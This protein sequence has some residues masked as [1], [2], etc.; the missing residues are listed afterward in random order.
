MLAWARSSAS[1][2][3]V[4]VLLITQPCHIHLLGE[5]NLVLSPHS[6]QF[7]AVQGYWP[8]EQGS[9]LELIIRT[10]LCSQPG[11]QVKRPWALLA[12]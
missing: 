4:I 9:A 2:L 11:T 12:L 5:H 1:C 8:A 7:L 6:S 3:H 10:S